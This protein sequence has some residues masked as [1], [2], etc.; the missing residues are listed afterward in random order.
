MHDWHG[1]AS[2]LIR[3]VRVTISHALQILQGVS[4]G[5][6]LQVRSKVLRSNTWYFD[7]SVLHTP[8][9][10]IMVTR[11]GTIA[12]LAIAGIVIYVAVGRDVAECSN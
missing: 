7:R 3:T 8:V 2:Y 6:I 1:E 5:L 4:H 10:S 9:S 11:N 12:L